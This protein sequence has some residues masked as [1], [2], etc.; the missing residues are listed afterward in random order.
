VP[1]SARHRVYAISH[2]AGFTLMEASRAPYVDRAM[3]LISVSPPRFR[4]R[5][6]AHANP[7][8]KARTGWRESRPFSRKTADFHGRENSTPNRTRERFIPPSPPSPS[9]NP[10]REINCLLPFDIFPRG[11]SFLKSKN[12]I[13]RDDFVKSFSTKFFLFSRSVRYLNFLTHEKTRG[14]LAFPVLAGP[15]NLP[16]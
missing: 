7:W 1:H 5:V 4:A 14:V 2:P 16:V 10:S 9:Q 11:S 15:G 12:R 8:I 3:N 13:P 6:S